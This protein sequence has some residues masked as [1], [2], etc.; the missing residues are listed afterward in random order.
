MRQPIP[1]LSPK[2]IGL[3]PLPRRAAVITALAAVLV[4]PASPARGQDDLDDS[5]AEHLPDLYRQVRLAPFFERRIQSLLQDEWRQAQESADKVGLR[6]M[7][8]SRFRRTLIALHRSTDAK[9]RALI[10]AKK[11]AAWNRARGEYARSGASQALAAS[12]AKPVARAGRAGRAAR[13]MWSRDRCAGLTR[14]LRG[15]RE[16]TS[17]EEAHVFIHSLARHC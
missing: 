2:L 10:G 3:A 4:V 12:A 5:S 7:S 17:A 1:L 13:E 15:G 9:I 6:R 8:R 11:F 14:L 16:M